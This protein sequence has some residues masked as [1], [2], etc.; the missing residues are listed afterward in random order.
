VLIRKVY[1]DL[2]RRKAAS[3]RL[4]WVL[5]LGWQY[6]LTRLSFR[7]RRPL[8]GP[9]LGTLVTNYTCNLSCRMC[10]MPQSAAAFRQAGARELGTAEMLALVDD[11]AALG[12]RGIGF[13]GGEPL[14]RRDLFELLRRTR[15]RGMFAHLNTNGT[16]LDEEKVQGLLDAGVESLN[17][18]LDGA[19]AATH[20]R[21]RGVAGAFDRTVEA[22]RRVQRARQERGA[23]LRLKVVAVLS[24]QNIGEVESFL[25]LGAALGVDCVELIPRQSVPEGPGRGR[26][27]DDAL[28]AQVADAVALLRRSDLPVAL[29]DSPGMLS[30]FAPTFRGDPS[31]LTCFAGYNSLAVDCYG[32]IFPCVPYVNWGRTVGDVSRTP[33]RSFWRSSDYARERETVARCRSCTLNCQAELNLL[34]QPLRRL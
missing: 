7:L 22:V 32:G 13:T 2:V 3:G 4:G 34:F 8:C 18:S 25:R 9:I 14:L 11:F 21:I 27:A 16:L 30:L 28:G 24:E 1:V 5:G 6:L 15:E 19:S 20:D 17:I 33:L 23:P 10:G 26:P 12:T 31:P 29:E